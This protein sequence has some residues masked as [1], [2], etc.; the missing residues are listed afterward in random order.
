MESFKICTD[1]Y[2]ALKYG[3]I[4]V[5]VGGVGLCLHRL[6]NKEALWKKCVCFQTRYKEPIELKLQQLDEDDDV[7]F[8]LFIKWFAKLIQIK[9]AGFS[10]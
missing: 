1:N 7:R 6:H 5:F 10:I 2:P 3:S 9:L 4:A 8:Y